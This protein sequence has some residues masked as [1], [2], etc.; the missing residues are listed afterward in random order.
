MSQLPV[1]AIAFSCFDCIEIEVYL[2]FG[3]ERGVVGSLYFQV[4]V[5]SE[6]RMVSIG[7][8]WS[9]IFISRI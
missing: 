9:W 5:V 4:Q 2:N 6:T 3:E 8:Y 1:D 7:N